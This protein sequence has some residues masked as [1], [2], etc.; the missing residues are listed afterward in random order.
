MLIQR[1]CILGGTGFVGRTLAN[2]LTRDG[3]RLR[4]LTRDRESHRQKLILLPT[5][6][7]VESDVHDPAQLREQF[8]DCDAVINLVGILNERGNR[9]LGFRKV[10]VELT[11]SVIEAC[12]AVGVQRYLHMS[13]LNADAERG[14]SHYLKTKGEA[15]ELALAAESYDLHV[16]GFQPSV[17][18][19]PDDSFFNRFAML[20]KITPLVFPLACPK[21]RFAPVY[22]ADVAEAFARSL[23]DPDTYGRSFRLCGPHEYTLQQLV[24]Y[25]AACAGM[26]RKVIPLNDFLSR[27]QAAVFNF[28]PGKPFSTDN[29]LSTKVDSVCAGEGDLP[30]FGITPTALEAVVPGYLARHDMRSH[31]T[32]FRSHARRR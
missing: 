28:V 26:K 32:D 9:G 11:R 29:Y 10:H 3:Y 27:M 5:T 14:P 16:T 7:L 30:R 4:I 15:E 19:G 24:E 12:R 17:I 6:E 21:A 22:V 20:L 25:T 31:Y 1:I 18:F 8:A 2:R 13:A 23:K